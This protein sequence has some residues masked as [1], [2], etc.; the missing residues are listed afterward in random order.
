[1][2]ITGNLHKSPLF[3]WRQGKGGG[4]QR[5][6]GLYLDNHQGVAAARQ[7]VDFAHRRAQ[8]LAQ[9]AISG[10]AKAPHAKMF[11]EPAVPLGC[12][13]APLLPIGNGNHDFRSLRARAR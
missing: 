1:M 11:G 4:I 3:F 12:L 6:T 10:E 9:N 8:S 5:G 13:A 7:D 2:K